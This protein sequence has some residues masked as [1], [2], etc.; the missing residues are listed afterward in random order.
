MNTGQI[1]QE[2]ARHFKELE[3]CSMCDR[4]AIERGKCAQIDLFKKSSLFPCGEEISVWRGGNVEVESQ[5]GDCYTHPGETALTWTWVDS[6][7]IRE[8]GRF[9]RV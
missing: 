3:F 8:I 9:K 4:E 6:A 1:V 7:R 2:L 5:L